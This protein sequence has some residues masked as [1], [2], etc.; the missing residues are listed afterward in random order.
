MNSDPIADLFTR[1]RNAQAVGLEKIELPYSEIK[2][3]IAN[4]M[5]ERGFLAKVEKEGS[6]IRKKI[7]VALA[8]REGQPV[9]HQIQR[10]SKPGQRIY[11]SV[12]E[13]KPVKRGRGLAIVSSSRGIISDRQARQD[14]I[15]GELIGQ[16]W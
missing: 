13:I 15:G 1:I 9:I 5:V 4:L 3:K 14:N 10:I 8:Y 2:M 7:R 16:M 6:Q 12:S 11:A